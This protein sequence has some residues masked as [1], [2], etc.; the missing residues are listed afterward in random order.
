MM[1]YIKALYTLGK[2]MI[3]YIGM[4]LSFLLTTYTAEWY[5]GRA[6]AKFCIGEGLNGFYNHIW[7]IAS[8][9]CTGLLMSHISFCGIF[10]ASIGLT[11]ISGLI[12][13]Y[14]NYM[15]DEYN[16]TKILIDEIKELKKNNK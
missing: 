2:P 5:S 11:F 13:I 10:I 16:N 8:P 12:Y 4:K 1:E 15:K 3:Y 9:S 6:Y 14:K 7:N